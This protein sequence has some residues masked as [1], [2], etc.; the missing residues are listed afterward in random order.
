ME[1][2]VIVSVTLVRL[3]LLLS[4][5]SNAD[6]ETVDFLQSVITMTRRLY[7]YPGLV[8]TIRKRPPNPDNK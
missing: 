1:K 8:A 7:V 2:L 3:V 4:V 6:P 5:F